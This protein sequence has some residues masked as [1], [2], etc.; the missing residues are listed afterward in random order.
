MKRPTDSI[1][2]RPPDPFA[3]AW[4]SMC[5]NRFRNLGVEDEEKSISCPVCKEP[6]S[7]IGREAI[8]IQSQDGWKHYRPGRV[9]WQHEDK[10]C[11]TGQERGRPQDGDVRPF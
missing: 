8:E 1:V 9:F 4:T 3:N 2:R 7:H 10:T 11:I 5:A 6:C